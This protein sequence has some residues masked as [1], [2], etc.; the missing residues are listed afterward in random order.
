MTAGVRVRT[1][2][3]GFAGPVHHHANILAMNEESSR[4]RE[5]LKKVRPE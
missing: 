5:S 1:I 2:N 4:F 3:R